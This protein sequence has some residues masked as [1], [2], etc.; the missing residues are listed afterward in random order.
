MTTR[1]S[2]KEEYYSNGN[3]FPGNKSWEILVSVLQ[4]QRGFF[5]FLATPKVEVLRPGRIKSTPQPQPEPQQSQHQIL[6]LPS[7]RE[8]PKEVSLSSS[9]CPTHI[10]RVGKLHKLWHRDT[11]KEKRV[12]T[13]LIF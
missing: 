13:L 3:F 1:Q 12:C 8:T 10:N 4:E 5:L 9:Y 7:H 2:Q 6:N 11:T